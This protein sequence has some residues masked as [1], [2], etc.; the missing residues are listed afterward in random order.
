MTKTATR[1]TISPIFQRLQA[2][3][4]HLQRGK[5][6]GLYFYMRRLESAS[7]PR[8]MVRGKKMLMFGSNNYLG[9]TTHP[10][11][12]EATLKATEKYGVGA[13]SV[14]LLGGTFDLHEELE[15][16][17]AKFKGTESAI[18]YSSGYVSN[19]AT[20]SSFL[21]SEKD[22]ALVDERIHASLVDG[23]RFGQIPFRTFM[24]NDMTDLER[25]LKSLQGKGNLVVIIDGVYSMDGD[26]ANLPAIHRLAGKYEA[27]LMIDDAHA[28][29]VLG[30]FGRGTAEHFNLHGKV[31]VVLG[32][33]SKGLGGIG[34]FAA[35]PKNLISYLKH[36]ARAFVFSAALP[37]AM[38]AGLIAAMQVIESEPQWLNRLRENSNLMRHGLQQLGFD[39]ANSQTAIIPVMVGDDAAAYQLTRALHIKGIY[40]SPVTFPAVK[41]G[42]A[43]LR[44]S[45][46]ATHTTEDI[47]QA[48]DAFKLAKKQINPLEPKSQRD[49]LHSS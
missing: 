43:R 19:M 46:M 42:T 33:L 21:N 48:L 24:H 9:L 32:T 38:C 31:D 37:P 39:T 44:V 35:G 17:I 6:Q 1:K 27:V 8:I 22:F 16:C 11:V 5:D 13:G 7:S 12:K 40:V 18:A 30:Q 15:A 25:K 36:C 14:R 29:G 47:D 41:K 49:V 3:E 23:L 4:Q 10:K 45:M 28:T 26:I 34:G 2:F 20:I